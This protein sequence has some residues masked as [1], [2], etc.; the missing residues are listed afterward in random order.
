MI[1]RRIPADEH[2]RADALL[3]RAPADSGVG[4]LAVW[5]VARLLEWRVGLGVDVHVPE[6]FA[7]GFGLLNTDAVGVE[8]PGLEVG[9]G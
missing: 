1:V 7:E 5:L 9:D 2:S 4:L 8:A 3:P 6:L